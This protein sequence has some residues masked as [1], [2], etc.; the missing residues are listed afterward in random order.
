MS[1]KKIYKQQLTSI[2]IQWDDE[3]IYFECRYGV[4]HGD[5]KVK[6]GKLFRHTDPDQD[7]AHALKW[8]E[9]Y[10]NKH[11]VIGPQEKEDQS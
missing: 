11:A 8:L 7:L 9:H 5:I 10:I 2:E 1:S 6:K 3:D 4:R